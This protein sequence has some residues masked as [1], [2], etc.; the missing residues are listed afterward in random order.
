MFVHEGDDPDSVREV[1]I[2]TRPMVLER[3]ADK[4]VTHVADLGERV[5]WIRELTEW[6]D[7]HRE[8]VPAHRPSYLAWHCR[9]RSVLEIRRAKAGLRVRAGVISSR[10][11]ETPYSPGVELEVGGPLTPAQAA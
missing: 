3:Y 11:E 1:P 8:L 7:T 9:G 6:A 10:P 2:P 5:E 4:I